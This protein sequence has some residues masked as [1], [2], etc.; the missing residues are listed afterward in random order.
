MIN[1]YQKKISQGAKK[2]AEDLDNA[3]DYLWV[4][5]SNKNL[6]SGNIVKQ[7][8]LGDY[9]VD[10]YF[11]DE[12]V[13]IIIVNEELYTFFGL[14]S[15]Y[16]RDNYLESLEVEVLR[17]ETK[18]VLEDGAA[19]IDEVNEALEKQRINIANQTAV[20]LKEDYLLN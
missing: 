19:I 3:G 2:L 5:L 15:D 10:F 1:H 13:A 7:H 17:F 6:K 4:L 14:E 12:K 16:D 18:Q 20:D 8:S 11:P 9:T